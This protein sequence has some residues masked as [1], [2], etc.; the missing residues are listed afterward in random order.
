MF[1]VSSFP[2]FLYALLLYRKKGVSFYLSIFIG[3]SFVLAF[4]SPLSQPVE[5][6][7]DFFNLIFIVST[8]LLVVYAFKPYYVYS[9]K[10]SYHESGFFWPTVYVLIFFLFLALFLNGFIVYKS[11][12][13]IVIESANITEFK[14]D[15]LANELIRQWVDPKLVTVANLFSPMGYLALGLHFYF[16]LKRNV[17]LALI[18]FVLALNLPLNSLHGLSRAGM[19]HFLLVYAFMY[20]YIR[21]LLPASHRKFF[22]NLGG[23]FVFIFL[24]VFLF[25]TNARFGEGNY[26]S[27]YSELSP[28]W[29]DKTVL[30]SILDYASQWL[31]N[32]LIVL[33]GYSLDSI[34]FGKSFKIFEIGAVF[35]GFEYQSY[36]DVRQATLGEHASKFLGLVT[37]LIFD[38]GY[39]VTVFVLLVFFVIVRCLAPRKRVLSKNNILF[40]PVLIAAPIMF[41]TNNYF[42]NTALSVGV[43]L[44]ILTVFILN[45]SFR[46]RS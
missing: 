8:M 9:L 35:F 1:L 43:V 13:F 44:L 42:S 15:G 11:F 4:I 26:Y 32:A 18:F 31:S 30:I 27:R 38:F 36:A 7:K 16:L 40:F 45:L 17:L 37:V 46:R 41:F 22:R 28:F 23:I 33:S 24:S 5:T 3:L 34:W 25:I 12:S 10:E 29:H 6:L 21:P 2:F 20:L 14:N 39:I 19:V